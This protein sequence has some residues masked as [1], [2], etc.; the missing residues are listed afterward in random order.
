M[1]V[2]IY[3]NELEFSRIRGITGH[4]TIGGFIKFSGI[5]WKSVKDK[6]G[7]FALFTDNFLD[8]SLIKKDKSKFK[9]GLILEPVE[10][11]SSIIRKLSECSTYLDLILTYD[12]RIIKKF[13]NSRP[14]S[15]GG[16][17]FGNRDKLHV[18]TKKRKIS[19]VA[20]SKNLTDGHR[21]R[22]EI[23]TKYGHDF[24][25]DVYGT[26]YSPFSNRSDPYLDYEYTIVIENVKY[27]QHYFTEKLID[28]LLLEC[29]PIYW[30]TSDIGKCFDKRGFRE[31]NSLFELEEILFRIRD[32]QDLIN[33]E[34]LKNNRKLAI[35]FMSKEWNIQRVLYKH[36]Q[37]I[38]LPELSSIIY[39]Y[40]SFLEGKLEFDEA[41]P[42]DFARSN[43]R[44]DIDIGLNPRTSFLVG[45]K[46]K[47][48]AKL[49]QF[50]R[51]RIKR[52]SNS[53]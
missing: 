2:R 37:G 28:P 25:I 10:I 42:I 14:Y 6:P 18:S 24:D 19:L 8:T 34:P 20:S 1:D 4:N 36:F 22:H 21:L 17:L 29:I 40:P 48:Q 33:S 31:F 51:I 47:I 50:V 5:I 26:G 41:E 35:D 32:S 45:L 7:D 30:G 52:S 3:H 39:D 23:I 43:F 13:P 27:Q 11:D 53:D 15:P 44:S 9:V 49:V 38:D 46:K 16:T 12:E